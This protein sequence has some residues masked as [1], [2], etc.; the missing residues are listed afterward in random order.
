MI[1]I[2]EKLLKNERISNNILKISSGNE[3]I[4]TEFIKENLDKE[5]GEDFRRN[6]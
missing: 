4:D 6:I 3:I 2:V 1:K 5:I